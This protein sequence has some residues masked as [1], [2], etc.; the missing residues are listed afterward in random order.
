MGFH[1]GVSVKHCLTYTYEQPTMETTMLI[2]SNKHAHSKGTK[3]Y[4]IYNSLKHNPIKTKVNALHLNNRL[5]RKKLEIKWRDTNFEYTQTPE[6]LVIKL[7][8]TH[9][10]PLK[11][12]VMTLK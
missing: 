6:Y 4:N 5:A 11:N 10:L 7:N 9:L 12:I 3:K 2:L 1:K 8:R